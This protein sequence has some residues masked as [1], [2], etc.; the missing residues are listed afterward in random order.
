[1]WGLGLDLLVPKAEHRGDPRSPA[2]SGTTHHTE[3]LPLTLAELSQ[4]GPLSG[5][6]RIKI[7]PFLGVTWQMHGLLD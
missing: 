2:V 1:M 5:I 6:S 7:W 4:H 3:A